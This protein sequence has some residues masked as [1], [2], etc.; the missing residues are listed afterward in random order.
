METPSLQAIQRQIDEVEE[1][2]R[3]FQVSDY[4]DERFG[5]EGEYTAQSMKE[6]LRITLSALS[7]LVERPQ[8]M[9][10]DTVLDERL[11]MLRHIEA[12]ASALQRRDCAAVAARLD[13]LKLLTRPFES[14]VSADNVQQLSQ[15]VREAGDEAEALIKQVREA[16]EWG[17]V[18]EISASF[19]SRYEE[20][21]RGRRWNLLWLAGALTCLG[22]T[23]WFSYET[24][25]MQ[26]YDLSF[27][28]FF[29][30]FAMMI[31]TGYGIWFCAFRFVRY[32]NTLEDYAY[33]VVLS[34]SMA[35]FLDR[36]EGQERTA[37]LQLV[38]SE[39]HQDPLRNQHD[40]KSPGDR[41]IDRLRRS[42]TPAS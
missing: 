30:R 12:I 18:A 25:Q 21:K 7:A 10:R 2:L 20:L 17:A 4:A 34:K 6:A 11:G 42:K 8:Q 27:G 16:V 5:Q 29:A 35:A 19:N 24:V 36:F 13:D 26:N 23:I 38:L 41:V 31:A 14:R 15:R 3:A 28:F 32:Q 40:L 33:K 9:L 39:I 1:G 22:A 37:Y